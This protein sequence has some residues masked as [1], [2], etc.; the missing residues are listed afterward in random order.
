M[1]RNDTIIRT[2]T[3]AKAL[4]NVKRGVALKVL[5]EKHGFP[6]RSLYRDV[7]ALGAA[8]FPIVEN[9]GLYRLDPDQAGLNA[10]VVDEDE[11]LALYAARAAGASWKGTQLGRALDRLWMKLSS[12]GGAGQGKLL[13]DAKPWFTV[14]APFAVD[15]RPHEKKLAVIEDAVKKCRTITC[16]YRALSTGEE[17]TRTLEPA[18][19]HWDPGIEGLYVIAWCRL[20][21]GA[22]TFAAHRFVSVTLNEETFVP[23]AEASSQKALH[24]AFRM[25]RGKNVERV[26]I[27]FAKHV[28]PEIRERCWVPGQT[29]VD[30]LDGSVV[31]TFEVAGLNEVERWVMSFGAGARVVGP[32][33]L[34]ERVRA[35][36]AGMVVGYGAARPESRK[37]P[38]AK[39]GATKTK[40]SRGD[41]G[42][43]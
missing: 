36:V 30:Q 9:E 16:N 40:L 27:Q 31:L 41:N 2:L 29:L 4:A 33:D 43:S 24:K 17:T 1:A 13:P 37:A 39:V 6:L 20:R 10:T 34:V 23:R 15:Y 35:H 38:S 21:G 8:G 26:E 22:R 12:K 14:R 18:E 11:L 3:V 25:W 32:V 5:A 7:E 42:L 28:A 19:L